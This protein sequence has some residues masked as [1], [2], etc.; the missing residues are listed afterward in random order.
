[1]RANEMQR[2]KLA[3]FL[4]TDDGRAF[5]DGIDAKWGEAI[6]QMRRAG[7]IAQAYGG[8]AIMCTYSNMMESQGMDGVVRMLQT[9]GVEVPDTGGC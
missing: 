3:S 9:N 2:E 6:E 5:L 4:G 1:M 8:T 7:F